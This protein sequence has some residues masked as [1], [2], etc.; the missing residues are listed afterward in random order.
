MNLTFLLSFVQSIMINCVVILCQKHAHANKYPLLNK[1]SEGVFTL[2]VLLGE[3]G[4]ISGAFSQQ[5]H[6]GKNYYKT[7]TKSFCYHLL[8][9]HLVLSLIGFYYN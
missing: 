7:K 6:Q 5:G 8:Q 1:T 4:L 3:R 2:T 9:C